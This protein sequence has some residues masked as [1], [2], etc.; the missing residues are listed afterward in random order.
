MWLR[1]ADGVNWV[2]VV[3]GSKADKSKMVTFE[4]TESEEAGHA[5]KLYTQTENEKANFTLSV[6]PCF[7]KNYLTFDLISS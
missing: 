6:F 2:A 7:L 5:D 3:S 4:R 1:S